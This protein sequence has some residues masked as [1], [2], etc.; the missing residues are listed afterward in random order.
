MNLNQKE[1]VKVVRRKTAS[2][3][4][5]E[6]KQP[7]VIRRPRTVSFSLSD[8]LAG[9]QFHYKNFLVKELREKFFDNALL[10]HVEKCYPYAK[11]GFLHVDEPSSA[12]EIEFCILKGK[13]M[14]EK[15]LS[16][17]YI[18]REM[19][20]IDCLKELGESV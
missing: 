4:M 12:Q 7:R 16:Y 19:D 18:T 9:S 6:E 14:K 8:E 20:L 2:N 5:L 13:I 11:N 3:T 1:Q 15:N 10:W 17:I